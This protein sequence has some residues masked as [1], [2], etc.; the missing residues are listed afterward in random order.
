[1]SAA[2]GAWADEDEDQSQ[3]RAM[4][5]CRREFKPALEATSEGQELASICRR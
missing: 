5:M 4:G 3:K 1:M 2:L